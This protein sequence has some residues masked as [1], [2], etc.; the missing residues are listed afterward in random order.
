MEG[1]KKVLPFG[2]TQINLVFL[3]LI[4]TFVAKYT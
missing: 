4:R 3:S 2:K 1:I